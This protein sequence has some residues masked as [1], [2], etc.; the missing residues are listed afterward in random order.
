MIDGNILA[1]LLSLKM[2]VEVTEF[3]QSQVGDY[4]DP[5]LVLPF[6]LPILVHYNDAFKS[7]VCYI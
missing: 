5:T 1:G 7:S 6:I 3:F 4:T 2:S